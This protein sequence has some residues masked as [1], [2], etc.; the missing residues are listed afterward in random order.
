MPKN[1]KNFKKPFQPKKPEE[2]VDVETL[3][4]Q[5][6]VQTETVKINDN[7]L[8]TNS[9][10]EKIK[11]NKYSYPKEVDLKNKHYANNNTKIFSL[12]F[13]MAGIVFTLVMLLHIV[14]NVILTSTDSAKAEIEKKSSEANVKARQEELKGK[15]A[16]ENKTLVFTDQNV[17]INIKDYGNL[18]INLKDKAAPQ[19]TENFI[20]LVSRGYYNGIGFHRIVKQENFSV[21]QGGDPSGNGSGGESASGKGIPDELWEIKPEFETQDGAT[22]GQIKNEPKFKDDS[23]YRDYNRVTG[24]VVYGKGLVLMAKTNQPD[25]ASSQF[26]V[27]LKDTK[28]PAQYTVFGVVNNDNFET[29]DKISQNV[30]PL[31]GN[32]AQT[33]EVTDGKPDKLLLIEKAEIVK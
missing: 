2:F 28:L 13:A 1:K 20:R 23:L 29:L 30:S 16:E 9:S 33:G 7:D 26:F 15:L 8:K 12:L 4:S 5:T 6:V 25:S 21:I 19:T 14:P 3:E 27:T 17:N 32:P 18:K 31:S 10:Q 22:R 24:E 11:N